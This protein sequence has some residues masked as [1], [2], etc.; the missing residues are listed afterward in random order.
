MRDDDFGHEV[1]VGKIARDIPIA[2]VQHGGTYTDSVSGKPRQFDYR[3]IIR[4]ESA[5]LCLA[6]E[7]KNLNPL[8]PLV[9]CGGSRLSGESFHDLIESRTGNFRRC[10]ATVVGLSSITLRATG[11]NSFY[12]PGEFCGKSLMRIKQE[13][14]AFVSASDSDVYDKWSQA[15]SSAVDFASRACDLS[16]THRVENFYSAI[17][18]IVVVPDGVLWKARYD[19]S[20]GILGQPELVESCELYVARELPVGRSPIA[21][22]FTLSHIHFLTLTGFASFV[23]KMVANEHAWRKLLTTAAYEI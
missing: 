13:K 9:V 11:E 21:Q 2:Q 17:L 1:R 15:L 16:K 12:E 22:S 10:G 4:K 19:E 14:S 3:I 6:V 5:E 8:A 7:C 20:G 23:S 18:P